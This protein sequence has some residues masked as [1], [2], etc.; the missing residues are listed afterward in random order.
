MLQVKDVC[1]VVNGEQGSEYNDDDI[2]GN[3]QWCVGPCALWCC[4]PGW[5]SVIH[6]PS[7]GRKME[8]IVIAHHSV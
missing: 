8:Q 7:E 6:Y 1:R 4:S 3:L 5:G 2:E